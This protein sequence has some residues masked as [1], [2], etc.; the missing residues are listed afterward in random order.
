MLVIAAVAVLVFVLSTGRE[1]ALGVLI[2]VMLGLAVLLDSIE[3]R[4]RD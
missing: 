1:D 4:S 2:L 3:K